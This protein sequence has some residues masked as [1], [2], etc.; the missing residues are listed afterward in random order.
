MLPA[1]S[2]ASLTLEV[3]DA[4]G[5]CQPGGCV[6]KLRT[7]AAG[8]ALVIAAGVTRRLWATN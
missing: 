3:G 7:R 5:G 8:R 2:G 6:G 1:S 4:R